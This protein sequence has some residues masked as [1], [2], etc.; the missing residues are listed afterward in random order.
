MRTVN[1]VPD[2]VSD[3]DNQESINDT[4]NFGVQD[5]GIIEYMHN[6][7][8]MSFPDEVIRVNEQ[9]AQIVPLRNVMREPTVPQLESWAV[10]D[11]GASDAF[12]LYEANYTTGAARARF[13]S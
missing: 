8:I 7:N 13:A 3:D 6:I 10:T 12:N 11:N 2:L 9:T 4:P 1:S 5:D